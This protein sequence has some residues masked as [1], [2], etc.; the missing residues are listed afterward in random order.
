MGFD[1]QESPLALPNFFINGIYRDYNPLILSFDPFTSNGLKMP[2]KVWD[3]FDKFENSENRGKGG[4]FG[5]PSF[6]ETPNSPDIS[7]RFKLTTPL[8]PE[9][10]AH[11]IHGTIVFLPT[12]LP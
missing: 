3:K 8:A 1:P 2:P 11:R 4:E 6:R 9:N 7:A 12:N 5:A 10:H